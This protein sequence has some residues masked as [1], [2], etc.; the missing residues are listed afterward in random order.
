MNATATQHAVTDRDRTYFLV[1]LTLVVLTAVTIGVSRLELDKLST[2]AAVAIASVKCSLVLWFFMHLKYDKP[3]LRWM[4]LVT[5]ASFA[6]FII[7]LYCDY[8]A[9]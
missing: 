5:V 6:V 1:W 8:L 7:L 2:S 3:I 9:R 4:F